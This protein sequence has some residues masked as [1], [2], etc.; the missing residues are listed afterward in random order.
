M[1]FNTKQ[2]ER[3]SDKKLGNNMGSYE[4]V[5]WRILP[6][7]LCKNT[8]IRPNF[9]YGI[10]LKESKNSILLL[11]NELSLGFYYF[12]NNTE[13]VIFGSKLTEKLFNIE[14]MQDQY[15]MAEG[16]SVA[17]KSC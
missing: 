17:L 9:L 4:F 12:P 11:L 10:C 13:I 5:Q 6:K 15:N 1:L 2:K 3:K 14:L 16:G 7:N 8:S